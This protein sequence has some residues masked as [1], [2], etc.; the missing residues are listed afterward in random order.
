ML[1]PLDF[2]YAKNWYN[3]GLK[4]IRETINENVSEKSLFDLR[5][6]LIESNRTIFNLS[7]SRGMNDSDIEY[8]V[9]VFDYILKQL[10]KSYL[11]YKFLKQ[12]KLI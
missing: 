3:E 4:V 11:H 10:E 5:S 9:Q 6:D 2:R 8:E 1:Y 12:F 7:L